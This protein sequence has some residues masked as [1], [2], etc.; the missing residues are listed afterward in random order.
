[1]N[2]ENQERLRRAVRKVCASFPSEYWRALDEKREYPEAFVRAMTES[3]LLGA[4]IP[5]STGA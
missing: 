3:G 4:L 1:V 2:E 5:K